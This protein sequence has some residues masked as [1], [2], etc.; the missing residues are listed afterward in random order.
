MLGISRSAPSS[1]PD[2][3]PE[4]VT[5]SPRF[6]PLL[7]PETIRSG[8]RRRAVNGVHLGPDGFDAQRSA[9]C[10]GVSD[11]AGLLNRGDHH[12]LAQRPERVRERLDAFR[13]HTIVVGHE[14]ARH[15]ENRS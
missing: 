1:A 7:I 15:E 14:Y 8:V 11:R 10:Q 2:T 5:S 9:K 4:Y 12:D 6:Q 13:V 3:V